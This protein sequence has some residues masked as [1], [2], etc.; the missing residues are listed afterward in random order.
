MTIFF[1][2]LFYTFFLLLW[3]GLNYFSAFNTNNL[4]R[5][6]ISKFVEHADALNPIVFRDIRTRYTEFSGYRGYIFFKSSCDIYLFE[7]YIVVLRRYKFMFKRDLEPIILTSDKVRDKE[8]FTYLKAYKPDR[9]L[10]K[11]VIKDEVEFKYSD[12]KYNYYKM[13]L[14]LKGLTPDQ[15]AALERVFVSRS[16]EKV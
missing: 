11:Q 6:L 3:I 1:A 4:A 13:E 9:I 7:H 5:P 14:T 12:L 2:F 16:S 15:K 10:F 8:H